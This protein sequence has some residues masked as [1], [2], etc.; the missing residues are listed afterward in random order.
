MLAVVLPKQLQT[1]SRPLAWC[2]VHLKHRLW[3]LLAF[4]VQLKTTEF[5]NGDLDKYHKALERALLAFHT[6]KMSDINKVGQRTCN[7]V[8]RF[9]ELL[10]MPFRCLMICYA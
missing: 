6:S 7:L 9:D 5:A 2:L 8:I 10:L 1:T 3:R 4:A